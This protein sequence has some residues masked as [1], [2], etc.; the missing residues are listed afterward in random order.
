MYSDEGG[1]LKDGG[2]EG[3]LYAEEEGDMYGEDGEYNYEDEEEMPYDEDEDMYPLDATLSED[4]ELLYTPTG[5]TPTLIPPSDGLSSIRPPLE[6]QASL[7]QQ[8]PAYEQVQ[9]PSTFSGLPAVTQEDQLHPFRT[10]SSELP[11]TPT[12]PALSTTTTTHT[13]TTVS[14]VPAPDIKPQE[15]EPKSEE[16]PDKPQSR[17]QAHETEGSLLAPEEKSEEPPI[18]R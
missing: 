7:H 12:Q 6:K 13:P 18:P 17:E 4:Q 2:E 3:A 5:T 16:P 11:C 15:P 9:P 14:Q 1:Y 8:Q 10:D